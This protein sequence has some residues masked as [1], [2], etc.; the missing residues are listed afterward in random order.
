MKTQIALLGCLMLA[1]N[2]AMANVNCAK[3]P[4]G[5]SVAQYG[6]DEF[7]LG[8]MS[9]THSDN[10]PSEPRAM[11]RKIDKEMRGACLAK[12][13]G[14]NL[15][16]YAKLG[17]PPHVLAIESVGSIAAV[18]INW[19]G[20]DHRGRGAVQPP[21][22]TASVSVPNRRPPASGQT[23]ASPSPA[24]IHYMKV[25]SNF[26]ACPRMVDLERLLSAALIDNAAWP[27]AEE[28]GKRHG[29]IE[30]HAGDRVYRVR[31]NAWRGASQVRPEGQTK[32][33]WT[34]ATVIR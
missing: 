21:S 8:I 26:P 7:R 5:E 25:T 12:F 4:Y 34:D 29:C 11:R 32:T 19:D 24:H 16:R 31:T 13:Y 6:R 33:Y 18:A 15:P 20:R 17:L 30:L 2:V 23:H 22:S 10:H 3:A 14:E 1:W 28:A 27:Q 9:M